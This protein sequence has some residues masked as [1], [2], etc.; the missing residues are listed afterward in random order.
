MI[1]AVDR[2]L[3]QNVEVNTGSTASPVFEKNVNIRAPSDPA[4]INCRTKIRDG[5]QIAWHAPI[6]VDDA[7]EH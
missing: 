1:K 5:M 3:N 4:E 2:S 7:G 6:E